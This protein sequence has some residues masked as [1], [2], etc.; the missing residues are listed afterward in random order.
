MF[1]L[2]T[3]SCELSSICATNWMWGN[4]VVV[5]FDVELANT[6]LDMLMVIMYLM[7]GKRPVDM[8]N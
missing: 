1:E 7:L 8:N 5:P 6:L 4:I 2:W 3:L